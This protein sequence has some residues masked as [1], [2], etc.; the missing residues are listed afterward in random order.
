MEL[1][2]DNCASL[3]FFFFKAQTSLSGSMEDHHKIGTKCL[4]FLFSKSES[5]EGC[6]NFAEK[7]SKAVCNS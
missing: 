4:S 5:L 3:S 1:V 2:I 7:K 6:I